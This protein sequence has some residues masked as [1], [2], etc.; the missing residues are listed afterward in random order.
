MLARRSTA[1]LPVLPLLQEL[2]GVQAAG[3][4]DGRDAVLLGVVRHHGGGLGRLSLAGGLLRLGRPHRGGGGGHGGRSGGGP[5][6]GLRWRDQLLGDVGGGRRAPHGAWEGHEEG[7]TS[8]EVVW[9]NV[10]LFQTSRWASPHNVFLS[11]LN[12]VDIRFVMS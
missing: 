3:L 9:L 4:L 10:M 6:R 7:E 11:H 12:K 5:A 1:R 2:P 8:V